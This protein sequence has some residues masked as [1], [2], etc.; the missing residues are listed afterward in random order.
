MEQ[1]TDDYVG[2]VLEILAKDKEE[3]A[4]PVVLIEQRL[5]F[6]NYLVL[7]IA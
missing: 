5:D 6:S 1:C 4:D 3:T 7:G 2:Y